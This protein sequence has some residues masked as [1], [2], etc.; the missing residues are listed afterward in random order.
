MHHLRSKLCNGR[1]GSPGKLRSSS[2]AFATIQIQRDPASVNQKCQ[3]HAWSALQNWSI[4]NYIRILLCRDVSGCLSGQRLVHAGT[5]IINQTIWKIKLAICMLLNTNNQKHYMTSI[6]IN[7][8][9]TVHPTATYH[10][11][12]HF[13]FHLSGAIEFCVH[14][15]S[16]AYF[17]IFLVSHHCLII[18]RNTK[19]HQGASQAS[20]VADLETWESLENA[21]TGGFN[22]KYKT[23]CR[24]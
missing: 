23:C 5:T 15:E 14:L 17:I 8:H 20:R 1:L 9:S 3:M 19:I 22:I 12:K 13:K 16:P 4:Y 11:H 7:S 6:A 18:T 2:G 10:V 21:I 24:H